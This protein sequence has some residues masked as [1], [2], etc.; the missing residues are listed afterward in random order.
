MKHLKHSTAIG[1]NQTISNHSD[2][3]NTEI[4]VSGLIYMK[5]MKNM[6]V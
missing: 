2:N 4:I 6:K 1:R 5:T 3:A